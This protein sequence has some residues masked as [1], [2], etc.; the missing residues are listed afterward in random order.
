MDWEAAA[1]EFK[2]AHPKVVAP[3]WAQY[4]I[5]AWPQF[6]WDGKPL[7]ETAVWD[8]ENQPTTYDFICWLM[9]VKTLGAKNV[10]FSYY[11]SIQNWK[12]T[13][14]EAWK[15]FGNIVVPM[16][17]LMGMEFTVGPRKFGFTAAYRWGHVESLYRTLGRIEKL[18]HVK[19]WK[20]DYITITLRDTIK[21]QWKNS[22]REAWERFRRYLEGKGEEVIFLDDSDVTGSILEPRKRLELYCNA[23]ANLGGANGTMGMCM[24]SAA[25]YLVMNLLPD[26]P[27]SKELE[28]EFQ[29]IGF[30]VGSQFSFRNECQELSW[31]PDSYEN[32]VEAYGRHTAKIAESSEAA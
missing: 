4:L 7:P 30:P 8:L 11:G 16:C 18:P 28:Q 21:F 32:I 17:D 10:H 3:A 15:R 2:K 29:R 19:A 27:D 31:V 26:H 9:I 25:P 1:F 22:N 23:K 5:W 12:Y 24:F 14:A 20:Q 13:A 6:N